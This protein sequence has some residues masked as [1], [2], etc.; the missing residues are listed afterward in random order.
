MPYYVLTEKAGEFVA[1]F[2]STVAVLPRSTQVIAGNLEFDAT[3]FESEHSVQND[4]L[5]TLLASDLWKKEEKK[6]EKK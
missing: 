1:H 3:A 2:K 4:A 6:K 5:K